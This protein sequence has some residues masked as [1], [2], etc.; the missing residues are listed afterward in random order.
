VKPNLRELAEDG[1]QQLCF[2]SI[3]SWCCGLY[4]SFG[5]S[6]APWVMALWIIGQ[7]G[8][9]DETLQ[10]PIHHITRCAGSVMLTGVSC[11]SLAALRKCLDS[12]GFPNDPQD[13]L[14]S[15]LTLGAW[16][17]HQVGDD[18]LSQLGFASA[19][20]KEH[21]G[22]E[23]HAMPAAP[24][25]VDKVNL[26]GLLVDTETK[27]DTRTIA[28][29]NLA[30]RVLE[31]TDTSA[32]RLFI[33]VLPRFNRPW[34]PG[35]LCFIEFLARGLR[36]GKH[37][38]LLMTGNEDFTPVPANWKIRWLTREAEAPLLIEPINVGLLGLIPGVVEADVVKALAPNGVSDACLTLSGGRVLVGPDC[39][40]KPSPALRLDYDR[41]AAMPV[42]ADALRA[43][44]QLHGN[45]Y[46][47]RPMLLCVE[48]WKRFAEGAYAMA[49][50]LVQRVVTCTQVPEQKARYLQELQGMRLAAEHFEEAAAVADPPDTLCAELRGGLLLCKG[51]A[52][53]ML[54][55]AEAGETY[56]ARARALF[57]SQARAGRLSWALQNIYALARLRRGDRE[58]ACTLE[59]TIEQELDQFAEQEGRR[60]WH[61]TYVNSLNQARLC[62]LAGN[63]EQ[64]RAYYQRA[65]ATSLGARSESDA[66]YSN[67]CLAR[68]FGEH[69]Y[70][71]DSLSCW[72]RAGLHWA[73]ARTP[74]AL[75]RRVTNSIL[76]RDLSRSECVVEE[77][78]VV[79]R[80]RPAVVGD[81]LIPVVREE[82]LQSDQIMGT[83]RFDT[84][85]FHQ[86]IAA[87]DFR[88]VLEIIGR[89]RLYSS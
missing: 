4:D 28:A 39:R 30:R 50:E 85:I 23:T 42:L 77:L 73:A 20:L 46:Y 58:S 37:R 11:T 18:F 21:T 13:W 67:V 82:A 48:A 75:A 47:C 17:G 83:Q 87:E 71:W 8:T 53:L 70:V 86:G 56:L 36:T 68:L 16:R 60:D 89:H 44:A 34:W 15:D 27:G 81:D 38:L 35:D 31:E 66:I 65:F 88:H 33:V 29:L 9:T 7:G 3:V 14:V 57:S 25:D 64:A 32:S 12:H 6:L 76:S 63:F 72:I 49:T 51:W 52:L 61:W 80:S 45:C 40:R 79:L 19:L 41:L 24:D 22:G 69:G 54:D 43:Y 5:V 2:L 62:R 78:A 10:M 74:E 59:L 1:K 26:F 84:F 55:R